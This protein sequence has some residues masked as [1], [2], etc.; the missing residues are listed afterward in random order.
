M[1]RKKKFILDLEVSGRNYGLAFKGSRGEVI[2][3]EDFTKED[4]IT[5]CKALFSFYELFSKCIKN[6]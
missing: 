2:Q 5:L 3:W 4:Q 6:D 1:K